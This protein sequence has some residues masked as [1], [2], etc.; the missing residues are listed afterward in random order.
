ME[1]QK[2]LRENGLQKLQED[3]KITVREYPDRVVFNYNQIESPKYN[4][5]CDECRALILKNGTWEVMARSFDRFYNVGED[6]QTANFPIS[7]SRI[8]EKVDGSIMS[9]Y[10]DGNEWCVSTRSMAFAEG[11]IPVGLTFRQ[12]FDKAVA[13][14]SVW[15][16]LDD[17]AYNTHFT[18]V[19]ELTSP[20][21]R[22]V[23]PYPEASLTLIGA[24]DNRDGK[25][26]QGDRLDSIAKI[27]H[28]RRPLSY[29]FSTIEETVAFAKTLNAMDEGFVLTYEGEDRFWRMKCKNEKYL[30]IA[31]MRN[32]GGLSAKRVLTLV[33]ANDHA[34][35]LSYF[36][37]DKPYFDFVEKIWKNMLDNVDSIYKQYSHLESQKE[38]A[39][40]IIPNVKHDWEKG[41]MFEM[42]KKKCTLSDIVKGMDALSCKKLANSLNLRDKLAKE[43]G[44]EVE[45][46]T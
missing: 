40:A 44:I 22:V 39:L 17:I 27:M 10:W 43:F 32:N 13:K 46:D 30:A 6:K 4:S 3:L 9:V 42:R 35:Y 11:T 24:R 7:K 15:A 41:I 12:I 37:E 21:T 31:H 36:P 25:E 26:M 18:W 28:V 16:Y 2:Y 20:E 45:E 34:E 5:I 19:F 29:R 33:V 23:T 14:T 8:E 1:I 38:F